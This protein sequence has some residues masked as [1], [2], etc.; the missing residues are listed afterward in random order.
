MPAGNPLGYLPPEQ[1]MQL[2][3]GSPFGGPALAGAQGQALLQMLNS[4][5]QPPPP[6]S[7]QAMSTGQVL[8]QQNQQRRDPYNTSQ[9][10]WPKFTNEQ[11]Y[12]ATG[13]GDLGMRN[14]AAKEI[15]RRGLNMGDLSKQYASQPRAR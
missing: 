12:R 14:A 4:I 7:Q 9:Y 6:V 13:L 10:D 11:L 15:Q 2:F 3:G 8:Q 5:T 1:Q